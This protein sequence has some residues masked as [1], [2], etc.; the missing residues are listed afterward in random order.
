MVFWKIDDFIDTFWHYLTFKVTKHEGNVARSA[1]KY[2][3]T[4]HVSPP[5]SPIKP[6]KASPEVILEKIYYRLWQ[7]LHWKLGQQA[8]SFGSI[9]AYLDNLDNAAFSNIFS[10]VK[11]LFFK[12]ESWN[13]QHLFEREFWEAS[14]D[15][16][17][18]SSFIYCYFHFFCRLSD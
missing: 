12:I 6:L 9:L 8:P 14:Q 13:F 11:R 2:F 4:V 16:N 5:P 3:P 17:S 7:N 15:F 1:P 10:R 18:F